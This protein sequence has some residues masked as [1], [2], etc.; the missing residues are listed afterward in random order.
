MPSVLIRHSQRRHASDPSCALRDEGITQEISR[1]FRIH[2]VR[3][4]SYKGNKVAEPVAAI[5]FEGMTLLGFFFAVPCLLRHLLCLL[6]TSFFLPIPRKAAKA[7]SA[8]QLRSCKPEI[9]KSTLRALELF[10]PTFTPPSFVVQLLPSIPASALAKQSR[11][12][13]DQFR[14]SAYASKKLRLKVSFASRV[15]R[16]WTG[17]G[18]STSSASARGWSCTQSLG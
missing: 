6:T 9:Q 8:L 5:N 18:S 7:G 13:R 1:D 4:C 10:V 17:V 16:L 14:K 15:T 3:P 11:A 2:L 12:A